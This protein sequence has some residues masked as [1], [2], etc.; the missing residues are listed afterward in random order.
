MIIRSM[1]KGLSSVIIAIFTIV[2]A[3]P[4][5]L[6]LEGAPIT[7]PTPNAT[8]AAGV[9]KPILR[10]APQASSLKL[11]GDISLTKGNPKVNLSL[12]DSDVK[13]V[14]R[15]FADKAGLN[16]IF[17]DSVTGKVTMDLVNVP[18][19]DA[20][21]MVMQVTNLTYFVDKNTMIV[22]SSEA[23][24]TLNLAKQEMATIPVKYANASILADFLNKNIFSINKPGLSNSQ[25]AITNPGTNEILIFGTNNDYL[26]AKKVVAQFDIKPKEETFIVNH[27][28][29]REMSDLLC[30][31]LLKNPTASTSSGGGAAASGGTGLALGGGVTAC[32]VNNS[33]TAGTL[34]S[35]NTTSLSVT[36]FA[37]RG[38]I[39][40]MGG[41]A[42]QIEMIK[43]F[44]IA[45]DKKQ[46]QAYLE[47]SIIELNENGSKDFNN[48]WQIWSEFFSGKFDGTT[49]TNPLYPNFIRGDGYSVVDPTAED[50]T[51][52]L[53][54]I[55]KFTGTPT[56]TYSMNYLISNGKGRV[57]ANPRIM[58]TNGETST[59]D[60]S[61]DYIKSVKSE[62]LSGTL[63]GAVQRTYE[64][65]NDEGIK[66][67]LLPFISPDGYVTLNIKPEYSTIKEKV[68][69]AGAAAGSTDLVATL[70]QRRNLDL[71]NV[72]IKDGETLVIGGMIKENETKTVAKIPVLGDLPGVGM[73]FRNTSSTKEKQELVIMITPKIIKDSEDVANDSG[74]TL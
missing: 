53:Y 56:I 66:V 65:A 48:N 32:E 23:A 61:S 43:D 22:T 57:L 71:K 5:G 10:T 38:T 37:Q 18:L 11:E 7:T 4:V 60:L 67:E 41:S 52:V 27:T 1:K 20:F 54:E 21:K 17:H 68:Y 6:C 29:P 19:N 24:Q 16:I 14:L 47:I 30:N 44:I 63:A 12:R 73:F 33:L 3:A 51:E 58:I 74:A 25:I 39:S 62:V 64:I 70:L 55:A 59:I 13:Q 34:S 9:N 26:M 15:M 36:Y 50:P 69:A 2:Y 28:T 45:N 35:L 42:Q 49:A 31:M 46:P 8:I 72:R 40:V